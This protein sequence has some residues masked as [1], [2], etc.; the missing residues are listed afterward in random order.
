MFLPVLNVWVTGIIP[1]F[2]MQAGDIIEGDGTGGKSIYGDDFKDENFKIDHTKKGQ[3]SM[4]NCGPNTYASFPQFTFS[5][6]YW[7]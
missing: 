6:L 4:A 1:G 2:M 3:L 7:M 5:L